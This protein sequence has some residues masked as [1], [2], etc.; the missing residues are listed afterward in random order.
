V[1]ADYCNVET[2]LFYKC[3]QRV[4]KKERDS[5]EMKHDRLMYHIESRQEELQDWIEKA[6]QQIGILEIKY[7]GD[8]AVQELKQNIQEIED[9]VE[10][11]CYI[12]LSCIKQLDC[13][14]IYESVIISLNLATGGLNVTE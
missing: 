14:A 10:V 11:H 5:Y 13:I 12:H 2:L 7:G 6:R 9:I 4:L 3:V 8:L 1:L